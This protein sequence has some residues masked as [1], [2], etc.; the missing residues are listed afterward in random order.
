MATD[1][2]ISYVRAFLPCKV[3]MPA[4]I[5]CHHAIKVRSTERAHGPH[6]GEPVQYRKGYR[7]VL[8]YGCMV[9]HMYPM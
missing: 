2:F 9:Y 5:V 3:Q 6:H 4:A 8:E 1:I 7:K